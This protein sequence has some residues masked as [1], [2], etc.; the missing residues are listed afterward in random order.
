MGSIVDGVRKEARRAL[1]IRED[2][3]HGNRGGYRGKYE[4]NEISRKMI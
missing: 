3:G 4:S 1:E 2:M